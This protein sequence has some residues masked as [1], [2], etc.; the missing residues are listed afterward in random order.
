[1]FANLKRLVGSQTSVRV[2]ASAEA[3]AR[4]ADERA[5]APSKILVQLRE[6]FD[7]LEVDVSR[8]ISDVIAAAGATQQD[9]RRFA[10]AVKE[11]FGSCGELAGDAENAARDVSALA[12]ASVELTSSSEEIGRRLHEVAVLASS[13]KQTT[14][15]ARAS[16]DGLKASS[17]DIMPI[18]GLISSIAKRTNLLALNATI[19][20]AH[21]GA[22]GRGFAVVAGEVKSLALETQKAT[23][24]IARRLSGLQNDSSRLIDAVDK[25]GHFIDAA[26]PVFAAISTAV[27]EQTQ[28][29]EELSRSTG[30]T[31]TFVKRVS[32]SAHAIAGIAS[33]TADVSRSAEQSVQRVSVDAEKLRSRFVIFLRQTEIG[34]RRRHDRLPCERA[35]TLSVD[36]ALHSGH[37]IDLSEGGALVAIPC[38]PAIAKGARVIIAIDGIGRT[39]ARVVAHST[40][41]FHVEWLQPPLDFVAAIQHVLEEIHKENADL[42]VSAIKAAESVS[43]AFEEAIA[44][45]RLTMETLFDGEYE[46]IEGTDPP[47]YRTRALK[48]LE[49]ILPPLQDP[50]LLSDSHVV[51]AIAADRNAWLPVHNQRYSHPQRPNDVDWN[52]ANSRN[53]RIFDDRA[54]LAA[55]RNVRPSLIQTYNRDEGAGNFVM[56]KEIDA[57]IR[58]F[59]RHWGG[60]RIGYKI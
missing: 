30:E 36:L 10:Q 4:P 6:T 9:M 60:F 52:A 35:V 3:P 1:M 42:V 47:Q 2:V 54:G 28:T 56:M 32:S 11:I 26:W 43:R 33:S 31:S 44:T 14:D 18:A 48:V 15:E 7:L 25:I 21:A 40:M 38:E 8:L 23:D 24:E 19:E 34:S 17:A 41:G 13:A 37:T 5:E 57:P 49:D 58:V 50:L 20:A 29:T 16:V 46:P 51:F 12:S 59:G 55:V 22:A 53:R 27:D 45:R 39:A